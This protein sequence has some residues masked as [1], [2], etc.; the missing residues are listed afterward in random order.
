MVDRD[1]KLA[2]ARRLRRRPPATERLLWRLLRDR[3]LDGLKFR[4]QVPL[5]RYVAD[6]VCLRHRLN[7]EA[8]GPHH[9]DS[10]TDAARDAWLRGQGFRVLRFGNTAIQ[11][12]PDAVLTQILNACAASPSPL[13]Q[14]PF[15]SPLAGEGGSRQRDG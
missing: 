2:F 1:Q 14:G 12:F 13:A 15:P 11:A 4:R 3:R 7:V 5:G 10:P 6:F 9:Q 8:A